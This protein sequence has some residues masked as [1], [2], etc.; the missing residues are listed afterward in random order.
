MTVDVF[1]KVFSLIKL[2][3]TI[4]QLLRLSLMS[5]ANQ[6]GLADMDNKWFAHF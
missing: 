2:L 6:S 4:H 5:N 3:L 1:T